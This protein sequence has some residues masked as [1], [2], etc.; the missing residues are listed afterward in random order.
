[1]SRDYGGGPPGFISKIRPWDSKSLQR[2][3]A[4]PRSDPSG[5]RK[6]RFANCFRAHFGPA[7]PQLCSRKTRPRAAAPTGLGGGSLHLEWERSNGNGLDGEGRS[8]SPHSPKR[9]VS[10]RPQM[11]ET[12]AL[13]HCGPWARPLKFHW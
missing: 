2:T 5:H 13:A 9:P 1:M 12:A 7:E 4:T 11:E 10:A 3:Y 6:F 8:R